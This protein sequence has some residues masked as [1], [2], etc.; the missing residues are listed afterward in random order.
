MTA[1]I[2]NKREVRSLAIAPLRLCEFL[3]C[4]AR[5]PPFEITAVVSLQRPMRRLRKE[6]RDKK[7][8]LPNLERLN[9]D[10][11]MAYSLQLEPH[12]SAKEL[13]S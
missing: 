12:R 5:N 9:C 2:I 11:R 10:R 3:A 1:L 8:T 7:E 13:T 6:G 4:F